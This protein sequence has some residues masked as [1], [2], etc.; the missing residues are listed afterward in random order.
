MLSL[1]HH[2]GILEL[3]QVQGFKRDSRWIAQVLGIG[4]D[5]V[6]VAL[7]RLVR[8]GL[9]VMSSRDSWIDQSG[10]A[11]F[12]SGALTESARNQANQDAHE[13]A[14]EAIRSIP[15]QHRVHRQAILAIES[16]KLSQFAKLVDG[17]MN[18][19]QSLASESNSRDDVYL[20]E[21]SFLPVTTLKKKPGEKNG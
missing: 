10:D 15:S 14:M 19:L 4:V 21:V 16:K 5:E 17:F 2:Y 6:N 1:W 7:Q 9:L 12:R 20:M 3:I 8:L 11:E 13:L 18:E